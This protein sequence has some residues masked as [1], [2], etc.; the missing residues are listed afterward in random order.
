MKIIKEKSKRQKDKKF[1]DKYRELNSHHQSDDCGCLGASVIGNTKI[2]DRRSKIEN[3]NQNQNQ[4][5]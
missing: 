4:N 3:Q 1:I 2:E 5:R